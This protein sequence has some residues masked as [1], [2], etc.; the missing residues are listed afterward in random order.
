MQTTEDNNGGKTEVKKAEVKKT[1]VKKT[2]GKKTEGKK[3]GRGWLVT[4]IVLLSIIVVA[5]GGGFGYYTYLLNSPLPKTD[6]QLQVEGLGEKVEVIRDSYGVPHIYA[7]NMHDLLLAQGYVQA[8]DRWWQMEFFRHT[9]GGRIEEL[10]GKNTGLIATDI[11]LRTLGWYRVAEQEYANYSADDRARLDAFAEGVNAYLANKTPGELSV[12][13]SILGLTGVKFK[14]EPWRAVDTLAFAKLMAWDLSYSDDDEIMRSKLYSLMDKD[15]AELYLIPPWPYGERPTVVQPEDIQKMQ[16]TP[17][18]VAVK[19]STADE[20]AGLVCS[21]TDPAVPDG[22]LEEQLAHGASNNWVVGPSLT[23][24]GKP[25]LAND[26]HLGIQMPSIWYEIGLHCPDD[27]KGRP[28]DCVGFAFSPSPGIIIGHN[29]NIA[30][31]VTNLYFDVSD[32]YQIK[33]NPDN[34]LQYEWNGSWRDMTV[35]DETINF[36]DGSAP[37]AIK[38]RMTHF[39]PIINDNKFDKEKGQ[40]QGYNNKDPLALRWTAL[41]PGHLALAVLNIGMANNW[42]EFRNALKFWDVPSQNIIYADVWGNIGYQAPGMVPIRATNHSGKLPVPGWTDEFEWKGYMPYDLLPRIFNPAR[43]YIVTANQEVVPPEYYAIPEKELGPDQNYNLGYNFNAGYRGQRINELIEELAP[44]S[45]ATFQKIQGDNRLSSVGE[46]VPYL[47]G[48]KLEDS[49][50]VEL[51]DWLFKWDYF[52]NEDSPQ[53][54]LYSEFWMKLVNNTFTAELK[55]QTKPAGDNRQM[56]TI[57]LLLKDPTNKW[58]DDPATQDKV[59]TRDDILLKS[60]QEGY[61]ATVA[62]LGSDRNLWRWGKL[63]TATFVSDPL[64][65][66]GIGLIESMVNRGPVSVGGT[67]DAVNSM[68][69]TVENGDFKVGSIPSMR[70]IVDLGNFDNSVSVNSTGESG[71]PGSSWYG[72]MIDMWRTV[73]Y[74]PMLW[75]RQQIEAAA[76][77]KLMLEPVK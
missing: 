42:E 8:Q 24:S 32:H 69:W 20:D 13:Y 36:G 44:H 66:S 49:E 73:K 31:A 71:N 6:G 27:G 4:L 38:V 34:P 30:W 59:E 64:G 15:M 21:Y 9:C 10:T 60:F 65:Q 35:R 67:A 58:W 25:L 40:F 5:G 23:Q 74:H 28:Y 50:L 18:G 72:D 48:L 3:R 37:M 51:R 68:R 26:P 12:N 70:M 54:A 29:N 53:A 1:E 41:E 76:A 57:A 46:I 45:I 62:D 22:F 2:E 7:Q 56:W 63:H 43:G 14:V 39:G 33:V 16:S 47:A 61:A 17:S 77:H 52:F 55:D 75:T 11:Y 19:S